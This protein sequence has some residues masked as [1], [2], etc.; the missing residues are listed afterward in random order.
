MNI[1]EDNVK[2]CPYC[3][4]VKEI[5]YN[6]EI[7]IQSGTLLHDRY[8]IGKVL[9]AGDFGTTY[10]AWDGKLEQKVAIKEYLPSEFS[11]RASGQATITIFTGDKQE[12]FESGKAKF[13]DEAKKLA[14]F[15][16][17]EGI[18][19]IFDSFEENRTAYIVMEF[20]EGMTLKEYIDQKGKISEDDAVELLMPVMESL[21]VVHSAGILHRDISPDN[22]FIT[23]KGQLKLIDFGAARFA[24]STHSRSLTVMIKPGYSPEEQYRSRGDQGTYTDVYSLAATLYKMITGTTPPDAL[25]RRKSCEKDRKDILVVP[26]KLVKGISVVR[27]VAL[28]NALNVQTEDRTPDI[29]T[30]INELMADQPAKRKYGKIKKLD[31][32]TWPKWLKVSIVAVMAALGIFGVLLLTG[33]FKFRSNYSDK[34][35]VP[36]NM[37]VVPDIEG[38]Q[39]N[40][41]I[42]QIEDEKLIAV[43]SGNI[44]SQYVEAGKIV[45]QNPVAGS[46]AEINGRIEIIVSSGTEEIIDV[47]DGMAT[48]P[49]VLYGTKDDAIEKFEIAGLGKPNISEA[50]DENVAKGLV[51]SQSVEAYE[52]VKEGTVIDL[53]ISLGPKP[54]A[55]PNVIGKTESDAEQILNNAGLGVSKDYRENSKVEEGKVFEQSVSAGNEVTRGDKIT[56]TIATKAST[57]IV[58]NVTGKNRDDAKRILEKSGF[59]VNETEK[60]DNDAAK[61]TVISQTPA[62]GTEQRSGTTITLIISK[63]PQNVNIKLDPNG[64]EVSN[65]SLTVIYGRKYGELPE[66]KKPGYYFIGWYTASEGG[67]RITADTLVSNASE[68]TIYAQWSSNA[69][70]VTFDANGGTVGTKKINVSYGLNYGNLPKAE[71]TGYSFDGWYTESSGGNKITSGTKVTVTSDHTLYAKWTAN[72]YTLKFDVNS[73]GA[74][75]DQTS[76][77][78]TFEKQY[79]NL[80]GASR[81]GYG[82]VGWFTEKNGGAQISDT[83]IL[84]NAGDQTV[85]AHWKAGAYT[86]SFDGNG[87]LVSQAAISVEHDKQYGTLPNAE[88]TGY[89]FKG[90]F[91]SKTGGN[92]VKSTDTVKITADQILYARWTVNTYKVSFK[93]NGGSNAPDIS[94]TYDST[95]G[96][97]PNPTRQGFTFAGWSTDK[98]NTVTSGTAVTIA[99]NHTLYAKWTANV[100]KVSFNANGGSVSTSSKNVTYGM[101]YGTLPTPTRDYYTFNGWY[102]AA[103]G[104]SQVTSSTKVTIT[105]TQTLYAHWSANDY[106]YNVEYKSSNGTLLGTDKVTHTFG[107]T[108]TVSPKTYSGYNTPG[109]KSVTWNKTSDTI[110]FSYTPTNPSNSAVSWSMSG[111][112]TTANWMTAVVT[113]EYRNRKEKTIEMRVTTQ[114][115]IKAYSYDWDYVAFNAG[116]STNGTGGT[117]DCVIVEEGEWSGSYGYARTKT[118]TSDWFTV[119][120]LS[121]STNVLTMWHHTWDGDFTLDN[122]TDGMHWFDINIPKY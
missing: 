46:Y 69:Y 95:Y 55:M 22:I 41:A 108:Y 59:V 1:V 99:G 97:L 45:F 56:I 116:I 87:G 70:T 75:A 14:R 2:E 77:I 34:V 19:K 44:A 104:G 28:L 119:S 30:F 98:S 71:R 36:E 11:T 29:N 67:T 17:E 101:T 3:G 112:T 115:T 109:S 40:K 88:R 53:V 43:A 54:F 93:G 18:V 47:V 83:T 62:G 81:N 24:T 85:Y 86:V 64:G 90:W 72:T 80:P 60:Y 57:V 21:R 105:A 7:H 39:T 117:N 27:E 65:K 118:R 113:V 94:V 13:M 8:I 91:T 106:T 66:P 79:G 12:Q 100:Y 4:Y 37:V 84:K 49:Y 63:G 10:L 26:H 16:N 92:E 48:V 6:N 31:L 38:E 76:K 58:E 52:K 96:T 61:D 110:T 89:T 73:E 114:L 20:L 42:K 23:T 32:Y 50:Y 51:I 15:Q 78:I 33:V 74:S 120:N 107:S 5:S 103:S 122:T 121:A 111:K 25:V 35:I 82:F 102:T 68:H 9:G